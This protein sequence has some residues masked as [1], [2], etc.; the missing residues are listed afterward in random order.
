MMLC[1]ML[2]AALHTVSFMHGKMRSDR[3]NGI[4]RYFKVVGSMEKRWNTVTPEDLK[5]LFV[6]GT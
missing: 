1:A 4:E 6:S 3:C 5:R 2:H